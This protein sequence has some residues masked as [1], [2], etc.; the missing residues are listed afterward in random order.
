MKKLGIKKYKYDINREI[1]KI[2]L[3][4]TWEGISKTKKTL[5]RKG[6]IS[7]DFSIVGLL[8]KSKAK[9]ELYKTN[10]KII[11]KI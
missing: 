2:Y 7:R 1:A 11:E 9:D 8:L 6:K 3:F 10:K 5:K 4:T